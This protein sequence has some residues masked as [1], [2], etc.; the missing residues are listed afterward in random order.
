MLMMNK[1]FKGNLLHCK[2]DN[3]FLGTVCVTCLFRK[4]KVLSNK[5]QRYI[6]FYQNKDFEFFLWRTN[7]SINKTENFRNRFKAE[8]IHHKFSTLIKR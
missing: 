7:S 1:I 6:R 3:L 4:N 5:L 8:Q 2:R